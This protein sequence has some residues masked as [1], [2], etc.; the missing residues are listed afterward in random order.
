M[1]SGL[2]GIVN[3]KHIVKKVHDPINIKNEKLLLTEQK[4]PL[5]VD[6]TVLPSGIVG[7]VNKKHIYIYS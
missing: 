5:K 4:T 1:S 6:T 2:V 3:I 7:V